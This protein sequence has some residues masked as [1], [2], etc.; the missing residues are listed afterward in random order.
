ME[1]NLNLGSLSY[2]KHDRMQ[3]ISHY[4]NPE[5]DLADDSFHIGDHLYLLYM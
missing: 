3:T 2:S 5:D 1:F 4:L